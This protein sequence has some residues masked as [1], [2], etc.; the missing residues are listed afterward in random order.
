MYKLA[1]TTFKVDRRYR[2]LKAVGRGSYGIVASAT[3][4]EAGNRR[5]A[6][7]KITPMAA[8]IADAKHVL[9]EVCLVLSRFL[10]LLQRPLSRL[11]QNLERLC[12]NTM[13]TGAPHALPLGAP[14]HHF[15]VRLGS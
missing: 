4:A 6:I 14:K 12:F 3:D 9:R 8:H 1:G 2:D 5:V 10:V 11:F 15:D 13:L 7:K